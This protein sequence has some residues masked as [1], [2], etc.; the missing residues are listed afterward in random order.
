MV[1]KPQPFSFF[2]KMQKLYQNANPFTLTQ[3]QGQF[4]FSYEQTVLKGAE[5]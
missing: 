5:T 1:N 3:V 4:F 2:G